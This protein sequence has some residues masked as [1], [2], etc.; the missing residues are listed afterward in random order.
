[1]LKLSESKRNVSWEILIKNTLNQYRLYKSFM[2]LWNTV[3]KRTLN[4]LKS[5]NSKIQPYNYLTFQ[6]TEK[7][8]N[9]LVNTK[10]LMSDFFSNVCIILRGSYLRESAAKKFSSC[11]NILKIILILHG[12][13]TSFHGIEKFSISVNFPEFFLW[14]Q[15]VLS[16]L[17]FIWAR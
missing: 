14:L 2:N 9:Y 8:L 5:M 1:M 12:W 6:N 3:Y 11:I 17:I 13:K 15:K 10:K 4:P 16:A 7:T